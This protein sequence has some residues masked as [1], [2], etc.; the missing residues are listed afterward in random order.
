LNIARNP[1]G[2]VMGG[3][4]VFPVCQGL[5][6]AKRPLATPPRVRK[7][8][9]TMD[10]QI[11]ISPAGARVRLGGAMWVAVRGKRQGKRQVKFK[12]G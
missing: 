9:S 10:G 5:K 8:M 3:R 12:F 7:R 6:N 2:R 4:F 1:R 11:V